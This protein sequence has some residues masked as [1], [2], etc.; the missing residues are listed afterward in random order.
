VLDVT[1]LATDV[2]TVVPSVGVSIVER[3]GAIKGRLSECTELDFGEL[4]APLQYRVEI[5][6][7]FLAVL[8]LIKS[9]FLYV[10]QEEL[11][12]RILLR[13]KPDGQ[14]LAEEPFEPGELLEP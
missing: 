5:I 11:F 6:V 7:T 4:I 8:E 13:R 1:P 2:S 3:I 12:G 14:E 9:N 10:Q